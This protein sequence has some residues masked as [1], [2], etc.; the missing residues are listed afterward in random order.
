MSFKT[1]LSVVVMILLILFMIR[2]SVEADRI[3]NHENFHRLDPFYWKK[4][5]YKK[6][7]KEKK[8]ENPD[9]I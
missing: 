1:I 9:K 8:P 5:K 3:S 4:P 2:M 7:K 6:P